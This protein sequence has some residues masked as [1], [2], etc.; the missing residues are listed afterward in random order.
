M[1]KHLTL[2][3]LLEVIEMMFYDPFQHINPPKKKQIEHM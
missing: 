2:L 1:H 3:R